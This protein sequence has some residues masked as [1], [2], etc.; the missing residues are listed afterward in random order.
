MGKRLL[1]RGVVAILGVGILTLAGA[2]SGTPDPVYPNLPKVTGQL[3]GTLTDTISYVSPS[4]Q[5]IRVPRVMMAADIETLVNYGV[6]APYCSRKYGI[7]MCTPAPDTLYRLV[8]HAQ[9]FPVDPKTPPSASRFTDFPDTKVRMVA[10]GSIPVEATVHL[11]LPLGDDGLPQGL[12]TSGVDDQYAGV[13]GPAGD[14]SRGGVI[15]DAISDTAVT[16]ALVVRLS[17]LL[18]DG[19]AV[20][21]GSKCSPIAP[22]TFTGKGLGFI[23]SLVTP[24]G[25]YNPQAGGTIAGTLDVPRF[26]GCGTTVD[27]LDSLV[28]LM[29]SG[30]GFPV[31]IEQGK[32]GGC[33]VSPPS[34]IN[35][36][37][38]GEPSPLNFPT[39]PH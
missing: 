33:W 2:A 17:D 9:A 5:W 6:A 20:D 37:S 34:Q 22:A 30:Q 14:P 3:Q 32:I 21:V 26:S 10:F 29:A 1:R 31:T 23:D 27:D 35:P 8:I 25:R 39:R 28:T 12:R 11:S 15:Y 16:G 38:C 24:P 18:V 4:R 13:A 36:S 19:H 7:A